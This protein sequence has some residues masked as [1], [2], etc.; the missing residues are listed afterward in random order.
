MDRDLEHSDFLCDLGQVSSHRI[1]PILQGFVRLFP[2]VFPIRQ[3][4]GLN[5]QLSFALPIAEIQE[6][7]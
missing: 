3:F 5:E 1:K 2:R 6:Y 7:G 4:L